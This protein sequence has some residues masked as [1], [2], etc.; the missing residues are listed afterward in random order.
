MGNTKK[1]LLSLGVVAAIG[2]AGAAGTFSSF[3]STASNGGN[4]FTAGTVAIAL[5]HQATNDPVVSLG[6]MAIGDSTS[7]SL[8]ITNNGTLPA[9]YKLTGSLSGSNAS[10]LGDALHITVYEDTDNTG[11]KVVNDQT[12]NQFNAAQ[13]SLNGG[14]VFAK[15]GA[16]GDNHTYYMHISLP[17]TG[18]DTGDN[19]L[20]GFGPAT[21]TFTVNAVQRAGQARTN[22]STDGS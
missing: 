16:S 17:S 7:N 11:T 21:E 12:L 6:N 19:V 2:T 1:V 15:H 22:L 4:A 10:A 13:A 18:S 14:S 8:K 20:Q 9:S 5:D 3:T